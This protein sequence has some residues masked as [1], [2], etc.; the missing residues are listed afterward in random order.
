MPASPG[1]RATLRYFISYETPDRATIFGFLRLRLPHSAMQSA[2]GE[3]AASLLHAF[4]ELQGAALIRELHVYG[5]LV[6]TSEDLPHSAASSLTKEQ[7]R[8]QHTGFGAPPAPPTRPVRMRMRNST[9]PVRMRMRSSTRVDPPPV[10][11]TVALSWKARSTRVARRAEARGHREPTAFLSGKPPL[12]VPR[13][14][15]SNKQKTTRG[16]SPHAHTRL[17]EL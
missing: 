11:Q 7:L 10:L 16:S 15:G 5:Q 6:E 8:S 17:N 4:P 13:I 12:C 1:A 9:R 2:P 3:T 14:F